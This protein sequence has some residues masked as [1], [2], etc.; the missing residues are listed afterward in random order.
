MERAS[1]FVIDIMLG[2]K[3]KPKYV[4]AKDAPVLPSPPADPSERELEAVSPLAPPTIEPENTQSTPAHIQADL[5]PT[6]N[7]ISAPDHDIAA[8][9][10]AVEKPEAAKKVKKKKKPKKSEDLSTKGMYDALRTIF[11]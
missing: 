5:E 9:S 10:T 1:L 8:T 11:A 6:N 7:S 4:A 3:W 2:K